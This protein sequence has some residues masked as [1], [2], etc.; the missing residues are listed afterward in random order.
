MKVHFIAIGGSAMHNL[1]I[2]LHKKG[3]QVTGSDDE[4][5]E[6]SKGRLNKYGLLPNSKG[7]NTERI[8]T[9]LDFVVLG[10]HAKKGNPELEKAQDLGLKIMSYPEFLYEQSKDKTRVVIAGSHGKTSITSMILHALHY[11]D[12]DC[13]FM[14]G[15]QLEGFETMVKLTDH[16]EFMIL[17]GDEYLSSPMDLRPKFMH[18]HPNIALISGI[19]WDHVNVFPTFQNYIDQFSLFLD[20]IE[21]GGVVIYNELDEKVNEVIDNTKNEVK[22]F[23]YSL[24][25]YKIENG[26][27]LIASHTDGFIPLEIIGK[28]NMN[29]LEGARW[30][31]NQMG[32]SDEEFYE[33]IVSF[34]GAS[35]R[36]ETIFEKKG[37]IA[38][39]DFAH[40][41]SKVSAT[42]SAVKESFPD[43]KLVACFEL[44][45]FSS[46]NI[47]FMQEYKG[48][49]D[50][51]DSALIYF[52]PDVVAHKGLEELNTESVKQAFGSDKIEVFDSNS[53]LLNKLKSELTDD[54][55]ALIMSSGSFDGIDWKEE[56]NPS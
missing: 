40:A 34:K 5:F 22:K 44:H 12:K 19:A 29:N 45:T 26:T 48:S 8:T 20:T 49:M 25:D 53:D 28:H 27:Y 24:P 11:N 17:E 56:L 1:A 2:A 55:V 54:S 37:L 15:A 13:D 33:A 16:N 46:L 9:D 4:I 36:L 31:C 14:V 41:P 3:Y 52:N 32:L 30:I 43:K 21:P 18:Y 51:A 23:A 7:W 6:P 35:R 10:M 42:V 38:Y 47:K 39:R 50:P